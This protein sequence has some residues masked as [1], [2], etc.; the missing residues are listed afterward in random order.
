MLSEAELGALWRACDGMNV[1]QGGFVRLLLLTLGRRDEIAS[2]RWTELD[3]GD[4]PTTWTLPRERSKNGRTHAVHL[5]Q[6]ARDIIA[7]QPRIMDN[8]FVFTGRAGRQIAAFSHIKDLLVAELKKSN[9]D[10]GDWRF[11]DFRRAGVTH[12]AGMGVPPHVADRLLNHVTGT[13]QGVA[14]VYQR[15]EFAAERKAALDTWARL[16]LAAA[17]GKAPASN[18]VELARAG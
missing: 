2:M 6:A 8:P 13:I 15:A 5:S 4:K 17:E 12:L 1:V 7:A 14:A 9:A 3:D 11:H 18:V 10:L 16:I